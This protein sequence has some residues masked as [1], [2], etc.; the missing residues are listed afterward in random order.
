MLVAL[1]GCCSLCVLLVF[2]VLRCWLL[3]VGCSLFVVCDSFGVKVFVRC[4]WWL[5]V[6]CVCWSFVCVCCLFVGSLL[7]VGCW[8]LFVVRC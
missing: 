5:F 8:W 2:C 3:V 7:V 1:V 6:V 4:C